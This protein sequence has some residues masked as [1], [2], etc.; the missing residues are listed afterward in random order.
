MKLD[1]MS[2]TTPRPTNNTR[3][4]M[5]VAG[6]GILSSAKHMDLEIP[7]AS[8]AKRMKSTTHTAVSISIKP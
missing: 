8:L 2:R 3:I 5:D 7:F 4:F 6:S 1:T